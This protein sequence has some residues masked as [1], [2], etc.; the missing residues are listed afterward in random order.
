MDTHARGFRI[1]KII[2]NES[3]PI[4]YDSYEPYGV[5]GYMGLSHYPR[6]HFNALNKIISIRFIA[7]V[8]V[9]G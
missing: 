4:S 3:K 2:Q 8:R 9:H 1:F 5:A 7:L 6:V